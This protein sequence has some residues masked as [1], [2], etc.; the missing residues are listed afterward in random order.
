MILVLVFVEVRTAFN[1][2]LVK[3]YKLGDTEILLLLF[4]TARIAR[5]NLSFAVWGTKFMFL[6]PNFNATAAWWGYA[7]PLVPCGHVQVPIVQSTVYMML[8]S[9]LLGTWNLLGFFSSMVI[10]LWLTELAD[11]PKQRDARCRFCG[12]PKA[13]ERSFLWNYISKSSVIN[14]NNSIRL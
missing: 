7:F 5:L 14:W 8:L 6:I 12:L 10:V 1:F 2:F 3:A 9:S 11:L 4:P 13:K